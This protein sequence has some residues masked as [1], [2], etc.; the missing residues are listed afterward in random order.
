M[1]LKKGKSKAVR[2]RNVKEM[3]HSKTFAKGKPKS[4]RI[5]MAVAAAYAQARR[6]RGR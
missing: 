2:N 1:P 5:E 4:K 6:S 3:I